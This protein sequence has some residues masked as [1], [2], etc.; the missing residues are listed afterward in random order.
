MKQQIN[1]L[2]LLEKPYAYKVEATGKHTG[3]IYDLWEQM[4]PELNKKYE[5][6]E[7]YVETRNYN[8]AIQQVSDG[9]YDMLVAFSVYDLNRLRSVNFTIP[10]MLEKLVIAKRPM[11][12]LE[13]FIQVAMNTFAFNL[14]LLLALGVI[15]GY[16]LYLVEPKRG[17]RRAI[18]SVIASLFGEA[19]NLSERSSL[20]S[21]G[22]I[23]VIFIFVVSF[24]FVVY[25]QA[26]VTEEV[27]QINKGDESFNELTDSTLLVPKGYTMA[28]ETIAS[29]Y[30]ANVVY[31]D[32]SIPDLVRKY[33]VNDANSNEYHGV[34]SDALL[35]EELKKTTSGFSVTE[36]V[37]YQAIAFAV[38][39]T[40]GSL[41]KDA[42]LTITDLQDNFKLHKI[43]KAYYPKHADSC[44]L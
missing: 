32:N 22:M 34:L 35:I 24:C 39:M 11:N 15:L 41:L 29:N 21:Y 8:D 5:I 14:L 1:V 16:L 17:F 40:Q 10:I 30:G 43:C 38:N 33:I 36:P 13:Q 2:V 18:L 44:I 28:N 27:I 12:G 9:K 6:I 37:G 4:K 19:G 7:H 26:I 3:I 42:N 23:S 25:F 20:S 31:K